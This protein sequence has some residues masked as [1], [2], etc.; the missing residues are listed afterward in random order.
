MLRND[1]GLVVFR[2]GYFSVTQVYSPTL[3]ALQGDW[4]GGVKFPEKKALPNT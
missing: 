1:V 2:S 3:L 4:G